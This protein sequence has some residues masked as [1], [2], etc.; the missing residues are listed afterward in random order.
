M[1]TGLSDNLEVLRNTTDQ[2]DGT[3]IAN[4][5]LL[6]RLHISETT[7]AEFKDLTGVALGETPLPLGPGCEGPAGAE[8]IDM[9]VSP[10]A[11]RQPHYSLADILN[12]IAS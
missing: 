2:V 9:R 11:G 6:S 5:G 3:R 8:H 10:Q 4:L 1:T 12:R 7:A